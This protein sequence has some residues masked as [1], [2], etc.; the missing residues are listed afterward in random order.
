MIRQA[1]FWPV[2]VVLAALFVYGLGSERLFDQQ[3]WMREGLVRLAWFGGAYGVWIAALL[4][5]RPRWF[6]RGTL[7]A[8]FI[9]SVFV[10][11]IQAPLAALFL[12]ASAWALGRL[13]ALQGVLALV[14]GLSLYSFLIGFAAL[15]PLNYPVVYAA[16]LAVPLVWQRQ[17]LLKSAPQFG[18]WLEQAE[19]AAKRGLWAAVPLGFILL[20]HLIVVLGPEVSADGLAMHLAI[21]AS[22]DAHHRWTFDVRETTWAALPMA[23]DWGFTA[24]YLLGGEAAA[25]LFNFGVLLSAAFM[26]FSLAKRLVAAHPAFLVTALFVSSPVVQLVTGSLFV[27]NFWAAMLLGSIAALVRYAEGGEEQYALASAVM[28]GTALATKF[29]T[30]A[31]LAPV[32]ILLGYELRRRRV[33]RMLPAIAALVLVFGLPPYVGALVRTG[34][35]VYPFLNHIFKSPYFESG[36]P[37][38]D[39]RFPPPPAIRALY[40]LTFRTGRHF[41]GQNGGWTFYCFLF[42]PLAILLLRPRRGDPGW[43]ALAVAVPASVLTLGSQGNVR[44]LHPALPLCAIAA[45]ATL[46]ELNK[47]GAACYRVTL[48]ATVGVL[49]LN[50]YFMPAS[51][52]YHKQFSVLGKGQVE[53]YLATSAPGRKAVA[54]LNE[55]YP[56]APVV[57]VD[58]NQIAGLTGRAYTTTWHNAAFQNRI[59]AAGSPAQCMDVIQQLGIRL[60]V[61]PTRTDDVIHVALRRMVA[62]F[63]RPEFSYAGWQVRTLMDGPPPPLP[64]APV[65]P[66]GRYDDL[67]P[68]I[69]YTGRWDSGRFPAAA[70]GSITYSNGPGDLFRVTFE[71]S[72]IT[73]SYTKAFN[74]GLAEARI[75]GVRVGVVDLYSK[76]PS[77]RTHSRF[78]VTGAGPHV[79]EVRAL[80]QKSAGASD[81]F[82]DLDEVV[83]E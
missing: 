70:N 25:R 43:I 74:R 21:P 63:T 9:G 66:R 13:F 62:E 46:G 38:V 6:V 33:L 61:A 82:I 73:W 1:A 45:A 37:F 23:G 27:E 7:V 52:S 64:P 34:N 68:R 28:L 40:D 57:F 4:V 77:W 65:L 56:A 31:Y 5:S 30:V 54:W 80:A 42:V 76:Q 29:G 14:V 20:M 83:V 39:T 69:E 72:G 50:V 8:A 12:F 18:E 15:M 26:V 60:I 41:E 24:A 3:V 2:F 47:R 22:V 75:D 48:A 59:A 51:G 58:S 19:D 67:D 71:G 44:Y 16:A 78:G 35:P 32:L 79:F 17:R 55:N 81:C 53:D 10:A 49:A 11:G 36:T